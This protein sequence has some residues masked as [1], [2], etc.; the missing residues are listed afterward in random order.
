VK[1]GPG[2][3]ETKTR[4]VLGFLREGHKVK[5]TIMFRGRETAHPHLG[6]RILDDVAERANGIAK[7][8]AAPKLDGRNMIMVLAPDRRAQQ[9]Q[10]ARAKQTE[11]TEQ[12]AGAS[13]D[14]TNTSTRPNGAT[15]PAEADPPDAVPEE[16]R[17]EET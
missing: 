8:E 1:I 15:A 12:T 14:A 11:R 6:K 16:Q 9:Q 17:I 5:L 10:Q 2:D 4:K 13:G 3:F 7:V